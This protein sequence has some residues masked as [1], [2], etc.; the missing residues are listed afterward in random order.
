MCLILFGVPAA[1]VAWQGDYVFAAVLGLIGFGCFSGFKVGA[2]R[3]LAIVAG[4][5]AAVWF[6]SQLSVDF[7][8]EQKL[9]Q[10][11]CIEQAW[12][13]LVQEDNLKPKH[14]IILKTLIF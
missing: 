6:S 13:R 10:L 12:F 8:V 3:T 1:V 2:V 7:Q 9:T 14:N 5:I 4:I 11:G